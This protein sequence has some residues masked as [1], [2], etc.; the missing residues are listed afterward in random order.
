[1]PNL[2]Q[3][4]ETQ[5][6]PCINLC[7]EHSALTCG[8]LITALLPVNLVPYTAKERKIAEGRNTVVT[9]NTDGCCAAVVVHVV[10]SQ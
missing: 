3:Y 6:K 5:C 2:S 7:V 8:R 10:L 1:M 4:F 9:S